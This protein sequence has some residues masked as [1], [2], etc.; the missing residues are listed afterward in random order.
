[1]GLRNLLVKFGKLSSDPYI[2]ITYIN[3]CV[4]VYRVHPWNKTIRGPLYVCKLNTRLA[5]CKTGTTEPAVRAQS[6]PHTFWLYCFAHLWLNR[7]TTA[8]E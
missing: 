2:Y 8:A 1:M 4:C 7:A 5:V 6:G 3:V